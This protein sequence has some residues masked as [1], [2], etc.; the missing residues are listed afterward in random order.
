MAI[1]PRDLPDAGDQ[2][3]RLDNIHRHLNAGNKSRRC[4]RS[5]GS[6]TNAPMMKAT[7]S[8]TLDILVRGF[9]P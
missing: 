9:H 4:I 5:D 1:D 7:V 6:Q 2:P 3:D 8:C